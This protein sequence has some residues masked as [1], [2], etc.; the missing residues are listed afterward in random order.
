MAD[1][2]ER[3]QQLFFAVQTGNLTKVKSILQHVGNRRL[4]WSSEYDLLTTALTNNH[5]EI[6]KVL[7]NSNFSCHQKHFHLA[8]LHA[9]VEVLQ[10]IRMRVCK[11]VHRERT[12]NSSENDYKKELRA[13]HV[14]AKRRPVD[15]ECERV[16]SLILSIKSSSINIVHTLSGFISMHFAAECGNAEIIPL[17]LSVKSH[18]NGKTHEGQTPL[19]LAAA[20]CHAET[21]RVLLKNGAKSNIRDKENKTAL[22]LAVENEDVPTIEAFLE[23]KRRINTDPLVVYCAVDTNNASIVKKILVKGGNPNSPVPETG[24]L[25]LHLAVDKGSHEIVDLLLQYKAN[26]NA[27]VEVTGMTALIMAAEQ[28]HIEIFQLLLRYGAQPDA[29]DKQNR[30]A[31]HWATNNGSLTLVTALLKSGCEVT[32]L[33]SQE[34]EAGYTPLHIAVDKGYPDFVRL[35]LDAGVSVNLTTKGGFMPL[36]L[37]AERGNLTM[38]KLLLEYDA[39]PSA[40]GATFIETPLFFAAQAGNAQIV[41]ILSEISPNRK[42]EWVEGYFSL[43]IAAYQGHEAIVKKL[44][45]KKVDPNAMIRNA[46]TPLTAAA[47]QGHKKIVN[48]LLRHKAKVNPNADDG[49]EENRFL[50][51]LMAACLSGYE[52]IVQI[53][54]RRG[55]D[56][57]AKITTTPESMQY[58]VASLLMYGNSSYSELLSTNFKIGYMPIHFAAA[59]GN[60]RI[61]E[62]LINRGADI[63]ECAEIK[64]DS[65]CIEEND[66]RPICL[67]VE[68]QHEDIVTYLLDSGAS[69]GANKSGSLLL[70]KAI[71]QKNPCIVDL[72]LKHNAPLNF[73]HSY[74]GMVFTPLHFAV[75]FSN[76]QVVEVLL[77]KGVDVD[78]TSEL[79]FPLH[80]AVQKEDEGIISKLIEY[81]ACLDSVCSEGLTPIFHAVAAHK[82]NAVKALAKNGASLNLASRNGDYLLHFALSNRVDEN[83]IRVIVECGVDVNKVQNN[84]LP[85]ERIINRKRLYD[86]EDIL[87]YDIDRML[88]IF[89]R[90]GLDVNSPLNDSGETLLHHAAYHRNLE[91]VK[92]LLQ[93]GADFNRRNRQGHTPMFFALQNQIELSYAIIQAITRTEAKGGYINPENFVLMKR[94]S[95]KDY[96]NRCKTEIEEMKLK[97]IARQVSYFSV[98]ISDEQ[99]L[100]IYAGNNKIIKAMESAD[101]KLIFPVYSEDLKICFERGVTRKKLLKVSI[102]VLKKVLDMELPTLIVNEIFKNLRSTDLKNLC[103]ARY[104]IIFLDSDQIDK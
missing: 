5:M 54:L 16:L 63:N 35:F 60:I 99:D 48:I 90:N 66:A 100:A 52:E 49:E 75:M 18:I 44:L 9:N 71:F 19:H 102:G 73:T 42:D 20:N 91:R 93:Y 76:V 79:D 70:F 57:N 55:A 45:K 24:A 4:S 47:Q 34:G 104:P 74:S 67:A 65:D 78:V 31:L 1:D 13:I 10:I 41:E 14:F 80:C 27:V 95:L 8:I 26:P 62:M 39:D 3:N 94:K 69:I 101:L 84:L 98:L 32:S 25:A 97:K 58:E 28:D 89:L 51:P 21:V 56:I 43:F 92:L 37:A 103:R 77:K 2:G 11:R 81:G 87:S 83:M 7:L 86:S 68:K 38:V 46:L 33:F 64:K 40:E 29:K 61:V 17:L 59:S 88:M 12:D 85:I 36:H 15:E 53:L 82:T 22:C 30:T 23:T 96:H 6:A 50:T 72:L